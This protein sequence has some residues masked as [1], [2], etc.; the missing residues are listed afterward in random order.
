MNPHLHDVLDRTMTLF[1]Q[2]PR[3]LAGHMTGSVGTDKEDAF[4]DVDPTLLVRGED[5]DAFDRDLP[6]LF[7]RAGV[8]PVLWWPERINCETLRN[9][10]VL[11]EHGDELV[12]YD[13]T[14]EV[15]PEPPPRKVLARQVIFDKA[16]LLD[17][18]DES[19]RPGFVPARLGWVVEMYWLYAYIHAKY[20]RRGDVF[21]LIAVQH[22]LFHAHLAVLHAMQPA[23]P[24]D[25]W[26]ILADR[27]GTD[28][29][30]PAL[31]SYL[32]HGDA[33]SVAAALPV[34][35]ARFAT[36]A[37]AACERWD[38]RYPDAFEEKVRRHLTD[39]G[40]S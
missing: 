11:F 8:C 1:R 7:E 6:G 33:T 3:V 4:S 5:F 38:V 9:Y 20:L 37:R 36:D 2:D 15:A 32:T 30:I 21:K 34:Q 35:L 23:V 24:A 29:T 18:V 31:L 40:V 25:W 10:A 16:G 27:L 39:L 19:P 22:E 17:A 14:I 26:P 13:I 12:Q 28:Q